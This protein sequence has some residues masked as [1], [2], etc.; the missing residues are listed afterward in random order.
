M[1]HPLISQFPQISSL[2][3]ASLQIRNDVQRGFV[4]K[5]PRRSHLAGLVTGH[6][7]ALQRKSEMIRSVIA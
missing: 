1:P 4:M 7:C 5:K 2:D 3:V 6:P